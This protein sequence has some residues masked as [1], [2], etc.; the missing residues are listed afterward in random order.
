MDVETT[1]IPLNSEYKVTAAELQLEINRRRESGVPPLKG[2]IQ[3]SPANPTGAMLTPSESKEL[4]ELCESEGIWYLS[5]EIYMGI[6]FGDIAEASALRFAGNTTIIVNSFSKYYSMTGWRLGWLVL[7]PSLVD[8]VNRLN[9]NMFINA[10]TLSQQAAVACFE[11][12][13]DLILRQH[14]DRYKANREIVLAGLKECGIADVAPCHG[15]FYAYADLGDEQS[16]LSTAGLGSEA[17][18]AKLLED[19]GVAITPGTDFEDPI[20]GRGPQRIRLSF[21]GAT[22]D[23]N[24]AMIRFKRWWPTWK[25]HVREQAASIDAPL[26]SGI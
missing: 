12:A 24:E 25:A 2:F 22:E 19:E 5:D 23:I 13:S 7:P 17:L 14:V 4:A 15:A 26:T 11:P 20:L 16:G 21:P 8:A 9:Q 10:P 18:C 1:S 6:T 3:S